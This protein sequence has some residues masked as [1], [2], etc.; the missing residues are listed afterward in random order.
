M[1]TKGNVKAG[2]SGCG[3]HRQN[4]QPLQL[5]ARR[6]FSKAEHPYRCPRLRGYRALRRTS[7]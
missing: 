6:E 3:L 1:K 4:F 7:W 2:V 5:G